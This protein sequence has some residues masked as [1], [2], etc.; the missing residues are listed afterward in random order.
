MSCRIALNSPMAFDKIEQKLCVLKIKIFDFG[1]AYFFSY[2]NCFFEL[3]EDSQKNIIGIIIHGNSVSNFQNFMNIKN[4]LIKD[5]N[6]IV[7][8]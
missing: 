6:K 2:N 3:E 5:E 8:M 1:S 4:A 7:A